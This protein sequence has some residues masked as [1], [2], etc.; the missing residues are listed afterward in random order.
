MDYLDAKTSLDKLKP[1]TRVSWERKKWIFKNPLRCKT[2]KDVFIDTE[3]PY[4]TRKEI[5]ILSGLLD[6]TLPSLCV[7]TQ[8]GFLF[9]GWLPTE[10][11]LTATDWTS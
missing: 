4:K 2:I 3:L 9:N 7:L 11:D 1:I 5:S 8:E 6:K 10:D